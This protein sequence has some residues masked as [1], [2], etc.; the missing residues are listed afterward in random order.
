ME[1]DQKMEEDRLMEEDQL[2]K[3]G[4]KELE[5]YQKVV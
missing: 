4:L 2:M 5:Q 1:E 3:D